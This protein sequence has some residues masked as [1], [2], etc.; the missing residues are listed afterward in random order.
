M[1]WALPAGALLD[2][3]AVRPARPLADPPE[4]AN[5]TPPYTGR[6]LGQQTPTAAVELNGVHRTFG[7]V[8]AVDGIDLRLELG[9]ITALLGP[10]GAGKTTTIDMILGL[11]RPDRGTVS[12]LGMAPSEAISRGLVAAVL[13]TGGLL[14]DLTV[15][16]TV[17]RLPRSL[18]RRGPS[19]RCWSGRGSRTSAIVWWA[20]AR[21][22]SSSDFD[23][24]WRC[25]RTLP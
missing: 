6:V 2:A 23:L 22:A 17:R 11:G 3:R 14:K 13:Q 20:P 18:P 7:S 9:E 5:G 16:E 12:V 25:C 8:R 10:N 24:P 4:G 15:R 1:L 21:A 19:T